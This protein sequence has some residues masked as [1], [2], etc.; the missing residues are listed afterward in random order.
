MSHA[1]SPHSEN[2][3]LQTWQILFLSCVH[4]VIQVSE[5]QFV[6]AILNL[7]LCENTLS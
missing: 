2:A 3:E 6:I 5:L 7:L 1:S 4:S